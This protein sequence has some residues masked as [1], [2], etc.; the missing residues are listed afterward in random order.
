MF[1]SI[2]SNNEDKT[3]FVKIRDVELEAVTV[4]EPHLYA[5]VSPSFM[6]TNQIFIYVVEIYRRCNA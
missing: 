2:M 1:C 5:D 6:Q 4:S 3:S